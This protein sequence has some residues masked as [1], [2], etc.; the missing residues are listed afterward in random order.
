MVRRMLSLALSFRGLSTGASTVALLRLDLSDW[1]T[2]PNWPTLPSYWTTKIDE[3]GSDRRGDLRLLVANWAQAVRSTPVLQRVFSSPKNTTLI[4]AYHLRSGATTFSIAN[5]IDTGIRPYP[6][7]AGTC[8]ARSS[9]SS[10]PWTIHTG[11]VRTRL[12]T[13]FSTCS[14]KTISHKKDPPSTAPANR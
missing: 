1:N 4:S 6:P 7:N 5:S 10:Y 11:M 12:S 2:K 9:R 3:L 8:T 14:G 13:P